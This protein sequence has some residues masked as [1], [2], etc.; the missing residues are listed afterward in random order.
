[1]HRDRRWEQ[2]YSKMTQSCWFSAAIRP[3]PASDALDAAV[4]VRRVLGPPE[5]R[6]PLELWG[7]ISSGAFDSQ[8]RSTT[9]WFVCLGLASVLFVLLVVDLTD[10][11]GK[12]T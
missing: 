10:M 3:P 2:W 5:Q 11:V 8:S 6:T 12:L 9:G 1:M 4:R 7:R